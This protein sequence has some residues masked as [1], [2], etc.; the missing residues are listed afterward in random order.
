[1][2]LRCDSVAPTAESGGFKNS[3]AVGGTACVSVFTV[4]PTV[5]ETPD[6]VTKAKLKPLIKGAD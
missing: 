3:A 2:V 1:M 6:S 4:S 5:P